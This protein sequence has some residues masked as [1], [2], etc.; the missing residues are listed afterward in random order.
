MAGGPDGN[1][2]DPLYL[3]AQLGHTD[4]GL[5]LRVYASVLSR[6]D[7]EPERIRALVRGEPL[8]APAPA[9]VE[10]TA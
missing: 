2:V 10:E 3:A 6:K 7:G 5:S 9:T 4:P 8:A 1:P